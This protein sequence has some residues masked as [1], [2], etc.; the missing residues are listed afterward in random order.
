MNPTHKS[1]AEAVFERVNP[2]LESLEQNARDARRMLAT[3]VR[4]AEDFVDETRLRVRR[5]PLTSLALAV[6]AG[7]IAGCMLGVAVGW[8]AGHFIAEGDSGR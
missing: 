3:S 7:A 1:T 6:T 8:R 4:N 5:R 2:A